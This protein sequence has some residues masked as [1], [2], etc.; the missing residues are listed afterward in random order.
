MSYILGRKPVNTRFAQLFILTETEIFLNPNVNAIG[1]FL[2]RR[3]GEQ[4]RIHSAEVVTYITPH[5]IV[6]D[7]TSSPTPAIYRIHII[8]FEAIKRVCLRKAKPSQE[9]YS[10]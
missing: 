2:G 8:L 1:N 10:G 3:T 7:M 9:P 6:I 5:L 4:N